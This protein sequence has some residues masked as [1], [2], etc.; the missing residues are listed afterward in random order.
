V[1]P[2]AVVTGGTGWLGSALVRALEDGVEPAPSGPRAVR[3]LVLPDDRRHRNRVSEA[4]KVVRGDL[5]DRASLTALLNGAQGGTVFHCAGVI[6]PRRIRDFY[7][8]NVEGTRALLDACIRAKVRRFIHVSS[9]S[10]IGWS[11]DPGCRFDEASPYDPYMHYG[12]SKKQA[13][14][15]VNAAHRTGRLEAVIIRPPWFYGPGQPSRQ[16]TFFRMIK[17][18]KVPIIGSGE[19]RRSMAYVDNIVQGL[20]LAEHTPAA[21]GRTYW[22]ADQRP[23]SMNEIVATVADVL[24]QDFGLRVIRR[25]VRLPVV[26]GHLAQLADR[27]IQSVGLYHPKLH[28]LGELHTTIA[29]DIERAERELGYKPAIALREGMRRSVQALIDDGLVI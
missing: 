10:P 4:T 1:S 12:R 26:V 29:C 6:H 20:L 2:V 18:G 7:T 11:A 23:Y 25:C 3:C 17:A 13:E 27:S 8:V 28:V 22:I 15:L 21:A 9:N 16:T 5:R 14:D 19:N 24:E